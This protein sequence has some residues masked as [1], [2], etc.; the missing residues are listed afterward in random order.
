MNTTRDQRVH[1]D[2]ERVRQA[3]DG[4]DR[5]ACPAPSGFESGDDAAA[6]SGALLERSVGPLE[7]LPESLHALADRSADR[8][9]DLGVRFH[10]RDDRHCLMASQ[11]P[12]VFSA[13]EPAY[14]A[15]G[16]VL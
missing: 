15:L 14:F 4:L 13:R 2:P 10:G 1:V 12:Q 6:E 8:L 16:G 5:D 3:P 7:L 11:A 9:T